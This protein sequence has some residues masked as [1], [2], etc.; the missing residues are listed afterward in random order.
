MDCGLDDVGETKANPAFLTDKVK[1][2]DV[3]D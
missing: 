2:W 1:T 3:G